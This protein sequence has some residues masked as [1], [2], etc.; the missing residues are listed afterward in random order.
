VLS[1]ATVETPCLFR[2]Q[3]EHKKYASTVDKAESKKEVS[4]VAK[5][6]TDKVLLL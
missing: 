5:L 6:N 3:A 4:T 1:L 2:V